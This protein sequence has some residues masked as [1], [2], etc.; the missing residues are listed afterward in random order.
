[1]NEGVS[2]SP[3]KAY[4]KKF[5]DAACLDAETNYEYEDFAGLDE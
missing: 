1:V 3:R 2:E 4:S 5:S